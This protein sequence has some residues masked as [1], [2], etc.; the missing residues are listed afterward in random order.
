GIL[1]A[2]N[3]ASGELES[4]QEVGSEIRRVALSEKTHSV[5]AVRSASSGDEVTIISFDVVGSEETNPTAPLIESVSPD[6]VVQGRIKNLKLVVA[7]KNFSEGASLVVN[8][9][10]MGADL[11]MRRGALENRLSNA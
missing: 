3:T 10:E 6:I 7:G 9:V 4:Y 11:V 8:G 1:F 5:A 2:F